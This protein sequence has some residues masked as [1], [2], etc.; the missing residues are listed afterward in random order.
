MYL[1]LKKEKGT[2]LIHQSHKNII[3]VLSLEN[4]LRMARNNDILDQFPLDSSTH[5]VP[6]CEDTLHLGLS[7]LQDEISRKDPKLNRFK[8]HFMWETKAGESDKNI[9]LVQE[10]PRNIDC[11]TAENEDRESSPFEM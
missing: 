8:M 7:K 9:E 2:H 5:I 1:S 6:D 11:E 3:T 10:D 4:F